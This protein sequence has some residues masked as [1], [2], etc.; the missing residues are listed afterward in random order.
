MAKKPITR[1]E[2]LAQLNALD[3]STE[4][5][6]LNAEITRLTNE[7]S[8]LVG[9]RQELERQLKQEREAMQLVRDAIRKVDVRTRSHGADRPG[10]AEAAAAADRADRMALAEVRAGIQRGTHDPATGLAYTAE[11]KPLRELTAGAPKVTK[12][13]LTSF[14]PA[15][16]GP[17]VDVT[18]TADSLAETE[19]AQH[20]SAMAI[21]EGA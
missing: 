4:I 5:G 1:E 10:Q 8:S 11:T 3:N 6:R 2:L 17:E 14:F 12:T 7:N 15:L 16:S 20:Q 9:Q 21:A 13:E 18:D 19:L